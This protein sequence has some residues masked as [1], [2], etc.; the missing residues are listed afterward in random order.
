MV[1]MEATA[2]VALVSRDRV[3]ARDSKCKEDREGKARANRGRAIRDNDMGL[4][5]RQHPR[6][7]SAAVA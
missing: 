4:A 2:E 7:A 1:E 5:V 6:Q 3:K